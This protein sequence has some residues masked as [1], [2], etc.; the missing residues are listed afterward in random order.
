[1]EAGLEAMGLSL[2]VDPEW[3]LRSVMAIRRPEGADA[4]LLLKTMAAE[5][6]VQI[7]G[8][9]GLDIVRIGQMGEQCRPEALR[10]VL[11]AL[12]T[13]LRKQG[14]SVDLEAGMAAMEAALAAGDE[15]AAAR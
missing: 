1:M 10:R 14:V 12:G 3:R 11:H 7:A 4:A 8:A 5:H 15:V 9:F 2:F 13:C 6:N